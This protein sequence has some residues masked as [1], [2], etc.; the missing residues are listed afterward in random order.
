MQAE[1]RLGNGLEISGKRVQ[2][3]MRAAGI[4]GLVKVKKGRTTIRVP[5]VRGADAPSHGGIST[6]AAASTCASSPSAF[7]LR[8][9]RTTAR[10]VG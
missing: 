6:I 2:R 5:G 7:T 8:Y 3:L 9:S 4:S 1:L 10:V